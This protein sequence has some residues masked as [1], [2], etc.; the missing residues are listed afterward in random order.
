LKPT[1]GSLLIETNKVFPSWV[2]A[3]ENAF[4]L[5]ASKMILDPPRAAPATSNLLTDAPR[6]S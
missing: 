4:F 1:V 6:L 5:I 2:S 3:G